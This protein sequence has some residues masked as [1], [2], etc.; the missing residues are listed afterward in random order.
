[1]LG[2]SFPLQPLL[3]P[4][5]AQRI[6]IGGYKAVEPLKPEFRQDDILSFKEQ[7]G[8]ALSGDLVLHGERFVAFY[9][10]SLAGFALLATA[11][12]ALPLRGA[13]VAAVVLRLIFLPGASLVSRQL[14]TSHH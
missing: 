14:P 10:L 1:M 5:R 6:G 2:P 13:L 4:H 9:G 7:H 8:H 11:A 12:T 3:S